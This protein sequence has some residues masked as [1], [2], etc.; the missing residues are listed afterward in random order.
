MR[1]M[2]FCRPGLLKRHFDAKIAARNHEGIGDFHDFFEPGDC[3]WF[4]DLGED[5]GAVADDLLDLDHIF[6]ALDEGDGDPIDTGF[7]AREQIGVIL[8]RHR[9]ERDFRIGKAH[10]LPIGDAPGDI[11]HGYSPASA[12]LR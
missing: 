1:V 10:A 6:S 7:K 5:Q 11:D 3:L 8:R 2:R 12:K 9:G 4:L